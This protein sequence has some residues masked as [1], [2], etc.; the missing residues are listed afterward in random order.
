MIEEIK[1]TPIIEDNTENK[2]EETPVKKTRK[3]YKNKKCKVISK[4]KNGIIIDFDS[5]CIS[6]ESDTK[7]SE[8]EVQ[9][10]GEIGNKNF[11]V[12]LK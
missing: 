9:Y 12:K 1:E 7:D 11:E 2:L 4:I 5:Y 8:V 10:I 3:K 6:F